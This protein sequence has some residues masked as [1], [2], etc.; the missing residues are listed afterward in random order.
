M[1]ITSKELF[2]KFAPT[3]NFE[4]DEEDILRRALDVGFVTASP[5]PDGGLLYTVNEDYK[6]V[7]HE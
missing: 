7:N 6:G 4:L 2:N 3:F 5:N 1:I